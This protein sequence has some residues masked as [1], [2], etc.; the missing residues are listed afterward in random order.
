MNNVELKENWEELLNIYKGILFNNC[1][2]A[3]GIN[4]KLVYNFECP[5]FSI[6]KE[7]Y[8]LE[9]IANQGSELEK[10]INLLSFFAPRI[11]HKGNF[12]NSIGCNA[13]DLLEYC[14]DKSENG[15]NCL[16]KSKILQECC[17]ALGIY[18]RRIWL[19]PYSPYDTD[20]H[21]VI[22][23]Y[24][25][26]LKKWIMLDMTSNGY[27]VNSD[28][29]PLS[30]LEMRDNFAKNTFCEFIKTTKTHDKFF[31]D[32][33]TERLYYKQYFAKNLCYLF[34]EAQNEFENNNKRFAFIPQ[35]FDL[36]KNLKQKSCMGNDIPSVGHISM[37]LSAP[38]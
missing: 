3:N 5:Q 1:N 33:Q 28:G 9:S 21:V 17:L 30:I 20:N 36:V 34:V 4:E 22:E 31:A 19:M 37:L 25:F 26:D 24:D 13:I 14:L 2:F 29:L 10:A 7:K 32:M 12:Q 8:R 38:E 11:I 27:F 6:L 35:N 18:A 15:I 23:I 16:N